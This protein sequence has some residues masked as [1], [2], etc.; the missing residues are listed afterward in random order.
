[1]EEREY[2]AVQVLAELMVRSEKYQL[3]RDLLQGL[4]ELRPDD[5]KVRRNLVHT[6]LA[7]KDYAGAEPLARG[8]VAESG[9][10]DKVPALFFHAH[11]LWGLD[12]L[13]ESRSE[14]EL[15][16]KELAKYEK[17]LSAKQG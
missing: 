17:H 11:A 13:A 8:L 9:G 4:L 2:E 6:Q 3:A 14:V 15:Y 1:M 16:A 10:E 12:K 5:Q 7:L